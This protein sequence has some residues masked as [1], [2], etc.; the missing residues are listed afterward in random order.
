MRGAF[1][2]LALLLAVGAAQAVEAPQLVLPTQLGCGVYRVKGLMA[3][4]SNGIEVIRVYAETTAEFELPV[5]GLSARDS[6]ALDE[7]YAVLEVEI[8]REKGKPTQA[9][10]ARFRQLVAKI[11]GLH[12]A[13]DHAVEGIQAV[14][15]P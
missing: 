9:P 10:R 6:V 1:F 7:T 2:G 8:F 14:I 3:H 15:C 11:A 12:Q 13:N 4:R 5:F